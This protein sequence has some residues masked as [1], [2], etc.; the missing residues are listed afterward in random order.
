MAGDRQDLHP[1]KVRLANVMRAGH[2]LALHHVDVFNVNGAAVAE[3]H[4]KDR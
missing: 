3:E 4:H 2:G 1:E